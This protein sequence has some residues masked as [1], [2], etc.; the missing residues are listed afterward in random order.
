MQMALK[1]AQFKGKR[2]LV[3]L[4]E[5]F[6]IIQAFLPMHSVCQ[7]IN[8]SDNKLWQL[9]EKYVD[10]ALEFEDYSHITAIGMDET[11]RTKGHNYITLF[12]DMLKF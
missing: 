11:S 4:P 9:L 12:V 1:N 10:K 6:N 3:P 7:V 5:S 2:P 8:E